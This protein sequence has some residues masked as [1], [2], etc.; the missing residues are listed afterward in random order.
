MVTCQ[1]VLPICLFCLH[2]ALALPS[3][4]DEEPPATTPPP[5]QE[6]P[7]PPQE[8]PVL[9]DDA[10]SCTTYKSYV[11]LCAYLIQEILSAQDEPGPL[12]ACGK[13]LRMY[14]YMYTHYCGVAS[15]HAA[16]SI[17]VPAP[18]TSSPITCAHGRGSK[19]SEFG[20]HY[21]CTVYTQIVSSLLDVSY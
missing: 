9:E 5:P 3:T 12:T 2:A 10:V 8:T 4:S 7:P 6:T 13:N 14:I 19:V 11:I 17:G 20:S 21:V 16:E 1:T 18:R 15:S